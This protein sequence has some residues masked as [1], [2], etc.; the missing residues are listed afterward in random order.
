MLA[1]R[2]DPGWQAR[3]DGKAVP[4]LR[5]NHALSAVVLPAGKANLEFCYRPASML[6]GFKL[7]AVGFVAL[8]VWAAVLRR[9]PTYDESSRLAV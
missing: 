4:I 1:D 9:F 8:C 6:L 2:W 3:L 5:A 7:A